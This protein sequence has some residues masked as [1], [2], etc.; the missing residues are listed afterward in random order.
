[1]IREFMGVLGRQVRQ[2][3]LVAWGLLALLV[4]L[5]LLELWELRVQPGLLELLVQ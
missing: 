2:V 3:P 5:G 4:L 1:M